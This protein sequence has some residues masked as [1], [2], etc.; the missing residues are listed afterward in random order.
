[1]K[2]SVRPWRNNE[3]LQK[4]AA[5]YGKSTAQICLRWLL[6]KDIVP[7]PKSVHEE[8]II[9]NTVIF[10]FHLTDEDMREIDAMPY[11]GGMR[12]DPDEARS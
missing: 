4:I 12:F 1:M 11:C 5:K 10:D 3:T 9:A 6:Q 7:L 8:R 2:E